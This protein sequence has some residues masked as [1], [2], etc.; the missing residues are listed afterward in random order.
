MRFSK[1]SKASSIDTGRPRRLERENAH[2]SATMPQR[3]TKDV[4]AIV[5][6]TAQNHAGTLRDH[7]SNAGGAFGGGAEGG[8]IIDAESFI[9]AANASRAARPPSIATAGLAR[10]RPTQKC[11]TTFP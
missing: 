10:S 9:G 2:S 5:A 1:P 11:R 7:W 8:Q 3:P 6:N 4:I